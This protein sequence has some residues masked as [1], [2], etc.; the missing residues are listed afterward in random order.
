MKLTFSQKNKLLSILNNY[1][2]LFFDDRKECEQLIEILGGNDSIHD[3]Y[4]EIAF[5]IKRTSEATGISVDDIKSKSQKREIVMARSYAIYQIVKEL[6]GKHPA[7]T[8]AFIGSIF[9][10]KDHSTVIHASNRIEEWLKDGDKL[11]HMIH[12]NWL[13]GV[14]IR[15]KEER[16]AA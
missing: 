8:L 7:I 14:V 13:N 2:E 15:T 12:N 1:K 3:P 10:G 16:E 9:S 6:H 11:T 5:I 4:S